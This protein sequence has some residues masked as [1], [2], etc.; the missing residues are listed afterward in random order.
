[1]ENHINKWDTTIIA[2]DFN[3]PLHKTDIGKATRSALQKDCVKKV[4]DFKGKW[5]FVDK[6]NQKE[7][8]YFYTHHHTTGKSIKRLD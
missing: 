3:T 1:M 6:A 7:N 2:G 4:L 5:G 8:D